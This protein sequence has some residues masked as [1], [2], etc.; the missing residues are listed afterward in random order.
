MKKVHGYGAAI[1]KLVVP[2]IRNGVAP[3]FVDRANYFIAVRGA[4]LTATSDYQSALGSSALLSPRRRNNVARERFTVA[5][6]QMAITNGHPNVDL[7][8]FFKRDL[9][10]ARDSDIG[11]IN[12]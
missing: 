12:I 8:V 3:E 7:F 11:L 4:T 2:S 6:E 10:V 5:C 9:P 1:A